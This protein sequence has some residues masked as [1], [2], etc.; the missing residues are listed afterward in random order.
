MATR[1]LRAD[2]HTHTYY[3]RDA[4][5]SPGKYIYS[6]LKRGINCVAVT[7]H[8]SIAGALAIQELAPFKVIVGEEI[9]TNAGEIIGLFLTEEV[10][11]RLSPEE[12]VERI[13]RQGGL[14]S[15][16]HPFD[17]FRSGLGNEGLSRILPR[18]DLIESFNARTLLSQDNNK[19][20]TF[21]EE[22]GLIAI[23]VSD[24][25][26]PGELG[27]TFIEIPDFKDPSDFLAAIKQ[28]KPE[29]RPAGPLVHLASRW[30]VTR[31][32]LLRWQPV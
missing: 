19:A 7:E 10:P 14:V 15:I 9:K 3:S 30:A 17:R 16:P 20:R 11:A 22:N 5:T 25:H 23:A 31:R 28:A 13:K 24:A 32:K 27:G 18:I 1:T 26:S 12:T 6:C 29:E 8:N 4:L 2:L 21:A